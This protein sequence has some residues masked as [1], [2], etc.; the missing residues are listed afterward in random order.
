MVKIQM[1]KTG[2]AK[3]TIPSEIMKLMKWNEK[4]EVIFVPYIQNPQKP[5]TSRIP[6]I[7]KEKTGE[8]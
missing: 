2:Q 7:L 6:I 8:E 5:V 4:T 1:T 3:V